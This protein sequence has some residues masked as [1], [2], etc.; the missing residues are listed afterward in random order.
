MPQQNSTGQ[1]VPQTKTRQEALL[2]EYSEVCS[3]FRML[4]DKGSS[5]WRSYRSLPEWRQL[6]QRKIS[7]Q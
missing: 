3:N 7:K 6:W 4:T 1:V 2:K 5:S